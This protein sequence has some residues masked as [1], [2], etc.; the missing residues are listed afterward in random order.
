MLLEGKG[1]QTEGKGL[2]SRT[3]DDGERWVGINRLQ[4]SVWSRLQAKG[5]PAV[6]I[7]RERVF[8]LSLSESASL[9]H[10]KCHGKV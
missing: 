2:R 4:E 10:R 8:T 7:R 6:H 1:K 9:P 3:V 5:R